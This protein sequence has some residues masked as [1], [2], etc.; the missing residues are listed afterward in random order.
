MYESV[1][2]DIAFYYHLY[3]K[4][5]QTGKTSPVLK[6]IKNITNSSTLF[7]STYTSRDKGFSPHTGL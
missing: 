1:V 3:I 7:V 4:L 5:V 2:L 6:V